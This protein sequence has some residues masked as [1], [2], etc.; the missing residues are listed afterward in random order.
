LL[1]QGESLAAPNAR[2]RTNIEHPRNY[3][4]FTY[5]YNYPL[6]AQRVHDVL[7][8]IA[9]VRDRRGDDANIHLVGFGVAGAW[10]TAAA[11]QAGDVV[12]GLVVDTSFRFADSDELNSPHLLP[13]AAKYGDLE[14]LLSLAKP[15]SLV[16]FG[17]KD[18]GLA[19][20]AATMR[21]NKTKI[22]L[23]GESSASALEAARAIADE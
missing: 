23:P 4:G 1:Y 22:Q 13:G 7:S 19:G 17:A 11:A 12:S 2:S 6:F 16:I 14:A 15:K 3:A 18:A 8:V 20:L 5:G 21:G 9:A 10:A